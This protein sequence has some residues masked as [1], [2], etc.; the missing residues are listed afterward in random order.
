MLHFDGFDLDIE[1]G[2]L[3]KAG[4]RVKLQPQPMRILCL[5]ASHAGQLVSRDQIQKHIWT[6]E[7]FVDFEH[8]LNYSI[9][10]IRSALGDDAET[11]RYIETEPRRGYRFIARITSS[12]LKAGSL[13]PSTATKEELALSGIPAATGIQGPAMGAT[14][15]FARRSLIGGLLAAAIVLSY[16]AY[17]LFSRASSVVKATSPLA[18]DVRLAP[19]RRSIAV[20]GFRNLSH[21]PEEAWLSTALSEM[22]STE[23]AAGKTFRIIPEENIA[24]MKIDL[25]LGD[26][27]SYAQETL[28][29][30]RKHSG[31]D[32]VVSGSYL[33]IRDKGSRHLRLDFRLQDTATGE[34]LESDSQLGTQEGL[35]SLISQAGAQLRS[36]LGAQE[37]SVAEATSVRSSMPNNPLATQFYSQGLEKMRAFDAIAAKDLLEKAVATE[38][39][40]SLAHAALASAWAALGYDMR[41]RRE[42]EIAFRRGQGLSREERLSVEGQYREATHEWPRAFQIYQTLA[43]FYPDNPDYALRLGGAQIASGDGL[44]ALATVSSLRQL[45]PPID[46][47]PRIDYLEVMAHGSQGNYLKE[48][49]SA[50]RAIQNSRKHGAML[51]VAQ[52]LRL[53]CWASME[54]GQ[55]ARALAQCE[56]AREIF[57]RTGDRGAA[58][59]AVGNQAAVLDSQ[60]N[61]TAALEKYEQCL[62]VFRETGDQRRTATVLI[63]AGNIVPQSA[64]RR[65]MYTEALS[66]YQTIGD[67]HGESMS[68]GNLG[69]TFIATGDLP[70]AHELYQ[71]ALALA[72]GL[73]DKDLMAV[74]LTNSA[75]V[76]ADLGDLNSAAQMAAEALA[77]DRAAG[78]L[79]QVSDDLLRMADILRQQYRLPES[80]RGFEEAMEIRKRLGDS[81]RVTEVKIA[82]A[83]MSLDSGD[84]KEATASLREAVPQLHPA[85][86]VDDELL[87]KALLAEALL[88]QG[89]RAGAESAIQSARILRKSDQQHSN[90]FHDVD[91]RFGI[92]EN[93]VLGLT[94]PAEATRA[95]EALLKDANRRRYLG[96]QFQ[97]RLAEAEIELRSSDQAAA[98]GHLAL[99][100]KEARANGFFLIANWATHAS[101][102]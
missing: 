15:I 53:A 49:E 42:A 14:R 9:R 81:I 80:R 8:G 93:R 47:D 100:A 2:D 3:W 38:P 66:I 31:T 46:D 73:D 16:P 7:T 58:A 78:N 94:K 34:T 35:F 95:L 85:I 87:A 37:L 98:H 11:P 50:E 5:L 68:L 76:V 21:R 13:P 17:R 36:K 30:I 102:G 44:G 4:V 69:N 39:E 74:W 27:E 25:A 71:K 88:A 62:A 10:S 101:G 1:S 29:R 79:A 55:Q 23:L 86:F 48:G 40:Y 65:K 22:L 20:L 63:N 75:E 60:G 70:Q 6:E 61:T 96:Q 83:E 77:L 67:K 28:A 59:A 52:S 92:A 56:E 19:R 12:A 26:V 33:L 51:L 82:L 84:W 99:L 90:Q 41:A 43:T 54:T 72:R 97:I 32:M 64:R 45:P 57:S 18:S 89:D 91:V 24:R